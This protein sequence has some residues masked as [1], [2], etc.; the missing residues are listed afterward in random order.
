MKTAQSECC[1]EGGGGFFVAF[2]E[3][4]AFTGVFPTEL[5]FISL[6]EVTSG[7]TSKAAYLILF[8]GFVF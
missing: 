7:V 3:P 2:R 8:N 5:F 4:G 6:L 1:C